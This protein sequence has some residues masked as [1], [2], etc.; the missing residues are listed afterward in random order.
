[1]DTQTKCKIIENTMLGLIARGGE[2]DD[3][4]KLKLDP[5][6]SN[7]KKETSSSPF[8]CKF[9][10]ENSNFKSK[11]EDFKFSF[12]NGKHTILRHSDIVQRFWLHFTEPN[13]C[14]DLQ[15]QT[16]FNIVNYVLGVLESVEVRVGG[17]VIHKLKS[18][19]LLAY[20]LMYHE[21]IHDLEISRCIPLDILLT[22]GLNLV[23]LQFHT[24]EL[25]VHYNQEKLDHFAYQETCLANQ[26]IM[27]LFENVTSMNKDVIFI[28][29]EYLSHENN[30]ILRFM[31]RVPIE[32]LN[33]VY[34]S[35]NVNLEGLQDSYLLD[36]DRH[37]L[38]TIESDSFFLQT[39]YYMA[40]SL[41]NVINYTE[42][43]NLN[44]CPPF[45][46]LTAQFY[47]YVSGYNVAGHKYEILDV[48]ESTELKFQNVTQGKYNRTDSW[49]L[50]KIRNNIHIP[51]EPIHTITFVNPLQ[52][53]EKYK[54]KS[55]ASLCVNLSRMDRI[56]FQFT[57]DFTQSSYK[58]YAELKLHVG[59]ISVNNLRYSGGMGVL[60]WAS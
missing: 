22:T 43:T 34:F 16:K 26:E 15:E 56:T 58:T 24:A 40:D 21:H 38:A 8:H 55:A 1:M 50:D 41:A 13:K 12:Q 27:S 2:D 48:I 42:K 31:S 53:N 5:V 54:I 60:R 46:H 25:G 30:K 29:F 9:I 17:C 45:N 28:I 59:A 7:C 3:F 6:C 52:F 35:H 33:P 37:N 11:S 10:L 39:Q 36:R 23:A 57:L 19:T 44:V 18:P 20:L 4:Q 14:L 51:K 47:F 49:K 32:Y